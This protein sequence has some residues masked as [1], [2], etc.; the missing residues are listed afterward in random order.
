MYVGLAGLQAYDGY[1][2]IRGLRT[3]LTEQNPLVDGVAKHPTAFW[4]IKAAST[5]TMIY[6]AERM[7][8]DGH[9]KEAIV[10]LVVAN[11]ATG[12]AATRN[13]SFLRTHAIHLDCG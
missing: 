4:T 11:V 9:K 2:T 12:I 13:A 8:R 6:F 10:T 3:N 1:S 5:I 7:W